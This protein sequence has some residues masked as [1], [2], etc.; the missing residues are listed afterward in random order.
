M[1]SAAIQDMR[2]LEVLAGDI[3][4]G[5]YPNIHGLVILRAGGLVREDYF[6][7]NDERRG[8]ALGTVRFDADTLHDARSVTKSVISALFGAALAEGKIDDID[9]PVFD[10]F[11][12]YENLRTPQRMRIRL[13]HL[14]S[15]TSGI[16]WDESTHLYGDPLNS[17]TAM[18]RASDPYRYVLEQPIAAEPGAVWKYSGGDTMVLARIIERATGE[19]LEV[20]AKRVLFSPLGIEKYDWLRYSSGAVIAASGLR[21]RPRDMAKIGQLYLDEGRWR[22]TQILP[23]RWIAESLSPHATIA[24]RPFGF[25]RYGYQWWLGSARVWERSVPFAA[26]VGWGGQRIFIVPT[27]GVVVVITAGLYGDPRQ[28]DVTFE[29]ALDRI[30]PALAARQAD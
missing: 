29:I 30:L 16:Q 26:A 18:D 23:A 13:R 10:Y 2:A 27:M 24:D 6:E 17:E 15:M 22:G 4:S 20:F 7:G 11:P 25:Q 21:L 14:L 8:E 28:T 3:R 12:E 5:K 19:D 1:P 9:A